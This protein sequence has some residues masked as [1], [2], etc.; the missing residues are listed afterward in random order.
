MNTLNRR[1]VLAAGALSG[2]PLLQACATPAAVDT[3]AL[4]LTSAAGQLDA[5]MRMR[6]SN[7]GRDV[8]ANWWVTMF[9]VLPGER[10]REIFRLDGFNVGRFFKLPD[11]GHQFITREV[12]YYKDLKSGQILSEWDNPFTN[13]KNSVLQIANDPVNSRYAATKPGDPGR[14]PF[15]RSGDD[16]FLRIDVPLSYPN[17]LQP[18]EFPAESSGAQYTASEHFT[19]FG[20]ASD[21]AN[22]SLAS[23]P[24][25]WSWARTGPWLPWMK[26]GQRAG[27]L[28]YSGHGRKFATFAELPQDVRDYTVKNFP[29]YQKSPD[30]FVAPNETSWTYYKKQVKK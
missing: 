20:K 30:S 14:F 15:Q 19:F 24:C 22:K 4:D 25:T 17:P 21:L 18:G 26:M 9:A 23:V 10:P 1:L 13:T 28:M 16:V 6:A 3:S 8:F 12:A 27:Y 7:D 5:F 2:V 29:A 11:G